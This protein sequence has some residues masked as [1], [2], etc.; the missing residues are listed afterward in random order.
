MAWQSSAATAVQRSSTANDV[1]R[2][3]EHSRQNEAERRRQAHVAHSYRLVTMDALPLSA[4]HALNHSLVAA[5]L[6]RARMRRRR[7]YDDNDEIMVMMMTMMRRQ[8]AATKLNQQLASQ[9]PRRCRTRV[10][11]KRF[12]F[13]RARLVHTPRPVRVAQRDRPLMRR[14]RRAGPD[15]PTP[16][17]RHAN[18]CCS[19]YPHTVHTVPTNGCPLYIYANARRPDAWTVSSP[20]TAI[21]TPGT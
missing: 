16:I 2:L 20:S 14:Q 7:D 5:V 13:N 3:G 4:C 6:S 10:Q 17:V 15:S 21:R 1:R 18:A 8:D 19:P 12:G 11:K 9:A